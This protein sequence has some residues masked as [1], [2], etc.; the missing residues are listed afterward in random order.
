MLENISLNFSDTGFCNCTK[1]G[2]GLF[3]IGKN[4][5]K[6]STSPHIY[7]SCFE[8]FVTHA[9]FPEHP[10]SCHMVTLDTL[11]KVSRSRKLFE[12]V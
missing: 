8:N 3:E 5:K 11:L 7:F 12:Y 9:V 1:R 4:R 6:K 10:I 2:E